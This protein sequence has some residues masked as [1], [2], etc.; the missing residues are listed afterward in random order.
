M[1]N[2]LIGEADS[3]LRA[4]LETMDEHFTREAN[5]LT[6]LGQKIETH[7]VDQLDQMGRLLRS[8]L[9]LL[10]V[11]PSNPDHAF[12]QIV[13]GILNFIKKDEWGTSP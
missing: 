4:I 7:Y 5:R 10:V 8:V 11:V 1:L 9:G 2:G 13:E 3:L 12:F 6:N